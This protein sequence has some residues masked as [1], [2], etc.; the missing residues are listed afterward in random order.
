MPMHLS[1][2]ALMRK[3]R[4]DMFTYSS[5]HYEIREQYMLENL[6]C[7]DCNVSV[8]K[9]SAGEYYCPS[10]GDSASE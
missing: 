2:A 5:D 3:G 1:N 9:R 6:E 7:M 10:C 4:K 8:Q